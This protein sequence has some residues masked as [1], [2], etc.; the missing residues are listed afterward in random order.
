MLFS[1]SCEHQRQH[2]SRKEQLAGNWVNAWVN[3]S[4]SIW[5]TLL[6]RSFWVG[7]HN[8]SESP[9]KYVIAL[10]PQSSFIAPI[11]FPLRT[12]SVC[13]GVSPPLRPHS[14]HWPRPE[15][16]LL[17]APFTRMH[18]MLPFTLPALPFLIV[19]HSFVFLYLHFM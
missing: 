10:L 11:A 15:R 2:R 9:L 19:P 17:T 18:P 5:C 14:A 4:I 6:V 1:S 16:N 7:I 13:L 3:V 12:V 8:Y